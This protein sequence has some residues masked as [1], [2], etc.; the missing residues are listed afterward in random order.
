MISQSSSWIQDYFLFGPAPS[1]VATS[2]VSTRFP[3]SVYLALISDH[4]YSQR[5]SHMHTPWCTNSPQKPTHWHTAGSACKGPRWSLRTGRTMWAERGCRVGSCVLLPS[6]PG[7]GGPGCCSGL[8]WCRPGSAGPGPSPGWSS[9][10]WF[11]PGEGVSRANVC[12]SALSAPCS[13]AGHEARWTPPK[14][15]CHSEPVVFHYH[16]QE[17]KDTIIECNKP[18]ML[19]W[20]FKRC[21]LKITRCCSLCELGSLSECWCLCSGFDC[22]FWMFCLSCP[23]KR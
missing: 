6:P 17:E 16:C 2:F 4:A 19:F 23:G 20:T 7:A 15:W 18:K 5:Q 3:L 13:H 8:W 14:T 11:F 12:P 9:G 10:R 21:D 1:P 22:E